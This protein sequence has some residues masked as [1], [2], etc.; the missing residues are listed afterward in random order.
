MK[1][2]KAYLYVINPLFALAV[3]L[4]CLYA[5]GVDGGKFEPERIIKGGIPTYFVAK[6]IFCSSAMLLLGMAVYVIRLGKRP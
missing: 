2:F 1:L 3:L 5:A 6:G 4:I